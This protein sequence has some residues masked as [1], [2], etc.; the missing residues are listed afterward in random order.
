MRFMLYKSDQTQHRV[1]VVARCG[2]HELVI[3]LTTCFGYSVVFGKYFLN[4]THKA[5]VTI[6]ERKKWYSEK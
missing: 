3:I 2:C 4:H 6:F 5:K 1:K